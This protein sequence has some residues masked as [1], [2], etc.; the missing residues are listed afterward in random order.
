MGKKSEREYNDEVDGY[1]TNVNK[2]R[3]DGAP[4][5]DKRTEDR[6]TAV[7]DVAKDVYRHALKQFSEDAAVTRVKFIM[8]PDSKIYGSTGATQ[9]ECD[10]NEDESA[11]RRVFVSRRD[12]VLAAV[13]ALIE[14]ARMEAYMTAAFEAYTLV[15][16]IEY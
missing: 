3:T 2:H 9:F 5:R 13:R 14:A 4:D 7:N 15:I 11:D 1:K 10:I 16:S 6:N 12:D 8:A